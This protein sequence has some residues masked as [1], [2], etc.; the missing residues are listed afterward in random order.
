MKALTILA[1]FALTT[2]SVM[3]LDTVMDVKGRFD[4]INSKTDTVPGSKTSSGVLTTS[5]LRLVTGTKVNETTAL[6]LALDFQPSSTVDNNLSNTVDEATLTKT[7]NNFSVIIGK[8]LVLTGGR[9]NDYLAKDDYL[10]SKFSDSVTDNLTGVS[11]GYQFA[12][13]NLYLQYLQQTDS[14]KNPLT[15]KKVMGV[16]YYGNFLDKMIMPIVSYHKLGTNRPGAYDIQTAV[17]LRFNVQSFIVEA[18]Y[19]MLKQ[20]K[21]SNGDR[22]LTSMV[23]HIRYA[24]ESFQPFVKF[25][26]DDGKKNYDGIVS[27]S[28]KSERTSYEVGLEYIPNKDEDMR[29][30]VV[31]DNMKSEKKSPTPTSE[32][33]EQK[34]YAGIAFNYNILK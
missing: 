4:Y 21:T 34:I 14:T 28:E 20:E 30:H 1:T 25:I 31:Y 22:E 9:E 17:G 13:Q 15:D 23:G 26:K 16:V 32:V 8:Q 5:Y 33:K 10:Y 3:A 11:V 7:F 12:E 2:G 24:H 6:K 29:Y 27:G 19:L 18:D